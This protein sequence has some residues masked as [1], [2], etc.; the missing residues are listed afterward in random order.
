MTPKRKQKLFIILGLVSLAAIAVGLTLYALR[1]NIN[2]FFSPVQIAQGDA[3]ME[4]Q[5]RAGGMVKEGS[6]SRDPES[7]TSSLSSPITS[8]TWRSTTAASCPTCSAKAKAW[9][10]SESFR[11]MDVCTP[12]RC[13]RATTR[14][15]C[16]LKSPRRLKRQAIRQPTISPKLPRWVNA[17]TK[18]AYPKQANTSFRPSGLATKP[19]HTCLLN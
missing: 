17:W 15:I 19:E 12:I 9:W 2:L 4:R 5:I 11:P 3:P 14:T 16:P 10:W 6:V 8:M 13:L 7:W 1:A 18:K